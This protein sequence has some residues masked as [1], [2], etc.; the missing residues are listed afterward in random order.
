MSTHW[1]F[2]WLAIR[3][4]RYSAAVRTVGREQCLSSEGTRPEEIVCFVSLCPACPADGT[5]IGTHADVMERRGMTAV[6]AGPMTT[7]EK[8][9][10]SVWLKQPNFSPLTRR[11]RWAVRA[12]AGDRFVMLLG[13]IS[14]RCPRQRWLPDASR[15]MLMRRSDVTQNSKP[16]GERRADVA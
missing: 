1:G 7:T 13:G 9:S 6:S 14:R 12:S 2:R 5:A 3:S 8:K 10:S 4:R 15:G 16:G 11:F